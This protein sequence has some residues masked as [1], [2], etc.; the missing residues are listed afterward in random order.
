MKRFT[1][2]FTIA[3]G[4]TAAYLM[5]RRGESLPSIAKSAVTNPF[6]AFAREVKQAL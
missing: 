5:Y 6:G 2:W 4:A 1:F 3:A